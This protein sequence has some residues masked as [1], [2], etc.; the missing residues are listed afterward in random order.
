MCSHKLFT[1]RFWG[2]DVRIQENSNFVYKLVH[3]LLFGGLFI[4]ANLTSKLDQRSWNEN[5]KELV[6]YTGS[7]T[8]TK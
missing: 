4:P 3:G 8:I 1:Q 2:F 6:S 7:L 5:Q